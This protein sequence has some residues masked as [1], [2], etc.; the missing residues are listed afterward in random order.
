MRI[1]MLAFAFAAFCLTSAHAEAADRIRIATQKTGTFAWELDVI[2]ERGLDKKANLEL[3]VTELAS[4]EAGKIALKGGSADLIVADVMWVA[5]ERAIGGGLVFHP[6]TST[7]GAI[8]VPAASPVKALADLKGKKIGVAGGALDKS[9]LLLQAWARK[10]GFD[11]KK[12][13]QIVFGAPQLLAVKTEQGEL[14]AVLN[15]WNICAEL[16]AKGFRRAIEMADVEH[17]LGS[18][19]P[20]AMVGYAFEQKFAAANAEALMRYFAIAA[21]AKDILSGA[22]A[23]WTRIAARIGASQPE[24]LAII[25]KRYA[26]GVPRRPIDDEEADA[27]TLYN[28]LVEVGGAEFAGPARELD[29]GVYWRATPRI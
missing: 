13:A 17:D 24:A 1:S 4:P 2:R 3:V 9:W 29:K 5:R 16:E 27:R 28:V 19:G 20:V 18:K 22:P 10:R 26:D 8:M 11:P 12:D 15:Y 21:E 23:E 7:L 25:R 14:D 6:F